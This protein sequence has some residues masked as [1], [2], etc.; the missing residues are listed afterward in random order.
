MTTS[1]DSLI[2]QIQREDSD[3]KQRAQDR[4]NQ[5][6]TTAFAEIPALNFI[7][8]QG[9]TPG[10]NDGE[11]CVHEQGVM[12]DVYDPDYIMESIIDYGRDEDIMKLLTSEKSLDYRDRT[13]NRD[14]FEYDDNPL[15]EDAHAAGIVKVGRLLRDIKNDIHLLFGTDWR[16]DITRDATV[17]GGFRV[18]REDYDC[19]H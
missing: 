7:R 14:T 4:F 16:L 6:L 10:F 19:G 1:L 9:W 13:F 11:P 3:R 15:P 8:I 12:V 17:D 2:A 5:I 18:S